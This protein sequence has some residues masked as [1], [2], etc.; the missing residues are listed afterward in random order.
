MQRKH[1]NFPVTEE[2]HRQLKILAAK[3]GKTI[4]ELLLEALEKLFPNWR[5]EK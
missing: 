2:E 3:E 5:K 4:K 1:V